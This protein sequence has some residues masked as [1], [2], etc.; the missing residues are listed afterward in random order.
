ML[1][2]KCNSVDDKVIDSRLS[3]EGNSIRRRRECLGCA[4]RFTTYEEIEHLETF[5][6]KRD[7]RREHLDRQKLLTSFLKACEKRPVALEMME[8][9]VSAVLNHLDSF[10][11]REVPTKFIG[12]QVMEQLRHLDPVA[13]VRY[14]SVYRRFEEIGAFIEE[15]ES[16]KK[17][18]LQPTACNLQP[19]T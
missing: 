10:H 14:A 15:I 5:V 1:C 6:I 12:D 9:A 2:P 17:V 8:Q 13:Y 7:G 18:A 11:Q 3:K 19:A 4:H 16:L